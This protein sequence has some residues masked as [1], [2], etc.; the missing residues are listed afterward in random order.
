MKRGIPLS[1]FVL[2]RR[3]QKP[4]FA[5]KLCYAGKVRGVL[6]TQAHDA[7]L[8][9]LRDYLLPHPFSRP[10]HSVISSYGYALTSKR[11]SAFSDDRFHSVQNQRAQFF[12]IR[13]HVSLIERPFD[14]I[15]R[16]ETAGG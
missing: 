5:N 2:N 12:G 15:P 13:V 8:R 7:K 3:L 1:Q 14:N 16:L 10:R 4:P 9:I 6:L 11:P